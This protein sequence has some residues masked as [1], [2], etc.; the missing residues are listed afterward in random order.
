MIGE[1]ID[2]LFKTG[3]FGLFM[4]AGV[5]LASF[6]VA[7][8]AYRRGSLTGP[9]AVAASVLS[10]TLYL[11]GG[12]RMVFLLLVFFLSSTF[13]T[14]YRKRDKDQIEQELHEKKGAR[15]TFQV[16][17][18]G[19]AA[20]AMSLLNVVFKQ[21]VFLLASAA[22]LAA[23]N[24][25]TWASELGILSREKPVYILSRRPVLAGLSGGVTR[26]GTAAALAGGL[27]IGLVYGAM[28]L[29]DGLHFRTLLLQVALIALTGFAGSLID[30]IL[31]ETVQALYTTKTSSGLT[32][33]R[34]EQGAANTLKHGWR[35]MTNDWVNLI[36]STG[37]ALLLLVFL[38]LV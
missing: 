1:M 16:F 31:G 4:A 10:L 37:A 20:L 30:S 13:L 21:D 3:I 27:F 5:L 22:A 19:G 6:V 29:F 14:H 32:E 7:F 11:S 35:W 24:A 15:D 12:L 2:F 33:R 36:S 18:N 28:C 25:D 34:T 38:Y 9:A 17:A 23:S 8:L 26:F